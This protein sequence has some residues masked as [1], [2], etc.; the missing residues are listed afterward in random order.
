M[1]EKSSEIRFPQFNETNSGFQEEQNEENNNS[2]I[3][4][5]APSDNRLNKAGS[6]KLESL[7]I[8]SKDTTD[9]NE[10]VIDS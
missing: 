5:E 10:D 7:M 4:I 1:R 3:L 9:E 6:P 2:D 8:P